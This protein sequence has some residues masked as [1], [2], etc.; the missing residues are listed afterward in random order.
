MLTLTRQEPRFPALGG[1]GK[2]AHLAHG[3]L[4][5]I[6]VR[7]EKINTYRPS[8]HSGP[9]VH[10]QHG[11]LQ[12]VLENPP[13]F[14]DKIHFYGRSFVQQQAAQLFEVLAA[15]K[16]CRGNIADDTAG[17][18]P[19]ESEV[20][21]ESVKV[22]VPVKRSFLLV[23]LLLRKGDFPVWRVSDDQIIWPLSLNR[24]C[25]GVSGL[26]HIGETLV[27]SPAEVDQGCFQNHLGE[28]G[29]ERVD[30]EPLKSRGDVA[31]DE[32]WIRCGKTVLH[33]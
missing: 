12:N 10:A 30:F 21:K 24:Y 14:G 29:C 26:D 31:Q 4:S 25:K 19:S 16:R 1:E 27:S 6:A 22:C 18:D 17:L 20:G 32:R 8:P 5:F 2:F 3:H 23:A 33:P 15:E 28:P 7:P 9:L 11:L 13:A